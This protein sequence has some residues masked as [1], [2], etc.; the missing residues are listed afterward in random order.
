[1]NGLRVHASPLARQI[2][3]VVF[4]LLV[5]TLLAWAV[6]TDNMKMLSLLIFA[7]L[8]LF[9]AWQQKV[10]LY[11]FLI[12]Y[13][14]F[15]EY[16]WYAETPL[17]YVGANIYLGDVFVMLFLSSTVFLGLSKRGHPGFA[18]PVGVA[19]AL[20][21]GWALICILRG[22]PTWGHSALGESRFVMWATAYF[23]VVYSVTDMNEFK[24]LL[25]VFLLLVLS[26]VVY[27]E[28]LVFTVRFEGDLGAMLRSKELMGA[29]LVLLVI[30]IFA[31]CLAL[32]LTGGVGRYKVPV[33]LLTVLS[34]FLVPFGAR[35]GWIAATFSVVFLILI[36]LRKQ[37]LKVILPFLLLI[38]ILGFIFIQLDL[39]NVGGVFDPAAEKGLGFVSQEGR[40]EGTTAWR[41][42]GWQMLI[43]ETLRGS[44][45]L[46]AGFGG[47]YDIFEVELRG[48]PPHN[49]W[50]VIFSKMGA[51]GLI[52]FLVVISRFYITGFRFLNQCNDP[53][54]KSY[55]QGLLA[56][57]LVGL[58]GGTFFFFFP[59]MWLAVGL[60]TALVNISQ[61]ESVRKR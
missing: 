23:P 35:T 44:P 40:M 27:H 61:T 15:Y 42:F 24:R 47:Y 30:S 59:F 25:R 3:A 45:V 58:V 4:L 54:V 41:L 36:L 48:V 56:V 29:D 43:S 21:L 60:Q 1:V 38:G 5:A 6:A 12:A 13:I 33:T 52:L 14:W 49:D 17:L 31:F 46:G 19:V 34:G 2:A 50:L 18:S 57:F 16:F 7:M 28:I 9:A 32:L 51:V 39:F 10:L 55:M 8:L 26:Y 53:V 22:I 20:Y 37:G 11:I